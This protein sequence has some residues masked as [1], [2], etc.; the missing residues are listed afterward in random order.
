MPNTHKAIWCKHL[1]RIT[2]TAQTGFCLWHFFFS[3]HF[4]TVFSKIVAQRVVRPRCRIRTIVT[5]MPETA[6]VSLRTLTFF[7]PLVTNTSSSFNTTN[8]L[9]RFSNVWRQNFAVK[10]SD[11]YLFLPLFATFDYWASKSSDEFPC[12]TIPIRFWVDQTH[13]SSICTDFPEYH[14]VD[15]LVIDNGI[16]VPSCIK[17]VNTVVTKGDRE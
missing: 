12:R 11:L 5:L 8:P 16:F 3:T 7:S 17:F 13:V 4:Y 9:F 1:S 2:Y 10:V 15:F 14:L 6:L